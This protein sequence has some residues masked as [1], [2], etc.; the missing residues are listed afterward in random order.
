MT[1]Q[2]KYVEKFEKAQDTSQEIFAK[3]KI[4][5]DKDLKSFVDMAFKAVCEALDS[6]ISQEFDIDRIEK[7][8][9]SELLTAPYVYLAINETG[10]KI[11]NGVKDEDISFLPVRLYGEDKKKE[12]VDILTKKLDEVGAKLREMEYVHMYKYHISVQ[13]GDKPDGETDSDS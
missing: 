9:I 4:Q 3:K 10:I 1:F 8:E 7:G 2:K 5:Q 13:F 12:C 11:G 6:A